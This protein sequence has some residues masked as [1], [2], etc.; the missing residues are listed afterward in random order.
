VLCSCE[1]KGRAYYSTTDVV[2]YRSRS[3]SDRG[4]FFVL[5][6][7]SPCASPLG[8][9]RSSFAYHYPYVDPITIHSP[10]PPAIQWDRL[11]SLNRYHMRIIHGNSNAGVLQ[12]WIIAFLSL[13]FFCSTKKVAHVTVPDGRS[14]REANDDN[15]INSKG[16][17]QR[18]KEIYIY[19]CSSRVIL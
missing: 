14:K 16:E 9:G 7:L 17:K 2:G 18:T 5:L 11:L 15:N 4:S 19:I 10:T 1:K 13:F 8:R 12:R 6:F 3:T